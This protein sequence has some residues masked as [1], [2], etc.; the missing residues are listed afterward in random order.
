MRLVLNSAR[1]KA[2]HASVSTLLGQHGRCSYQKSLAASQE[3]L[4]DMIPEIQ[5]LSEDLAKKYKNR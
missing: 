1:G 3:T 5:K 4:A 2:R